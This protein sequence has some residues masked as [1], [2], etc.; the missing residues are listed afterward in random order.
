MQRLITAVRGAVLGTMLAACGSSASAQVYF[1]QGYDYLPRPSRAATVHESWQLGNAEWIRAQAWS[2]RLMAEAREQEVEAAAAAF[3]FHQQRNAAFQQGFAEKKA[4][5]EA[6]RARGRALLEARQAAVQQTPV[7]VLD[8][9]TRRVRWP[10]VLQATSYDAERRSIEGAVTRLLLRT[11]EA[12]SAQEAF[13]VVEPLRE[14]IDAEYQQGIL[15]FDAWLK[16]KHALDGVQ[17]EL[18]CRGTTPSIAIAEAR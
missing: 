3:K 2:A 10:R 5:Q 1:S 8:L 4:E 11:D 7:Q 14:R 9:A 15:T 12:P 17:R 16:A 6:Y 18:R 13:T